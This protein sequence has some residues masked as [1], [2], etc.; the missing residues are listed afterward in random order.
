MDTSFAYT[1]DVGTET[2]CLTIPWLGASLFLLLWGLHLRHRAFLQLPRPVHKNDQQWWGRL[3]KW[4][5]LSSDGA[6]WVVLQEFTRSYDLL[7]S[8]V[9]IGLGLVLLLLFVGGGILALTTT[10]TLVSL[11]I[12]DSGQWSD[13]IPDLCL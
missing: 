2:A 12:L 9:F 11:T 6:G 8:S 3:L 1:F 5:A 4:G 10:G 13:V 7:L